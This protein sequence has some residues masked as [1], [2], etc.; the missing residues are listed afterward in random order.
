MRYSLTDAEK[1]NDRTTKHPRDHVCHM[2][3]GM[4]VKNGG[5]LLVKTDTL[6]LGYASPLEDEDRQGGAEKARADRCGRAT[7]I[8]TNHRFHGRSPSWVAPLKIKS[9]VSGWNP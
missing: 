2:K 8:R 6:A 7:L 3:G 5:P 9:N 1:E 4:L